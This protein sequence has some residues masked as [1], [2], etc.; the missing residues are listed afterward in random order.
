MSATGYRRPPS[1]TGSTASPVPQTDDQ[2]FELGDVLIERGEPGTGLLPL[3]VKLLLDLINSCVH[4]IELVTGLD[5]ESVH[6]DHHSLVV[7]LPRLK[8]R[9]AGLELFQGRHDRLVILSVSLGVSS[10]A[11]TADTGRADP[12]TSWRGAAQASPSS[13]QVQRQDRSGVG[14]PL[15]RPAPVDADTIEWFTENGGLTRDNGDAFRRELLTRPDRG[16]AGIEVAHR[17]HHRGTDQRCDRGRAAGGG[18]VMRASLA[19]R[20]RRVRRFHRSRH[21]STRPKASSC[22]VLSIT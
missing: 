3:L 22:C 18:A 6:R 13:G 17:T 16:Q 12:H 14:E 10:M 9:D 15:S 4:S 5:P 21:R 11:R 8:H 19:Q 2:V 20:V 1:S 7:G